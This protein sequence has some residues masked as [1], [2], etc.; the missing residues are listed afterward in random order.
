MARRVTATFGSR[1]A[2]ERGTAALVG[3]GADRAQMSTLARGEPGAAGDTMGHHGADHLVEPAREVGDS[4]APLTTTDEHDAA[5]GAAAGAAIGAVAGLATGLA[6]LMVP[7]IGLVTAGG[8]LAWALGG[9]IGTA[10]A[11]AVAGGVYG[12]LRDIGIEDVHARTYEERVH[13]GDVLLSA[14][15]PDM[16]ES[17]V[18][19]TLEENGAD[20]VTFSDDSSTWKPGATPST[21]TATD[22]PS[23]SATAYNA[24]ADD[25]EEEETV[26]TRPL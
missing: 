25:I 15:I 8:A 12:S 10:A 1:E 6:M 7:G 4:G 9:A 24:N 23:K 20:Y 13:R 19:A 26:E 18:R 21:A 11:G 16:D 3:M 2:A 17:T 22:Y 14:V 5:Q